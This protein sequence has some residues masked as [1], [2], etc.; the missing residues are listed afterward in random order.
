MK[1]RHVSRG[2]STFGR[3]LVRMVAGIVVVGGLVFGG[4]SLGPSLLG[5]EDDPVVTE[6]PTSEPSSTTTSSSSTSTTAAPVTTVATTTT[7]PVRPPA[8][9]RVLVL[10]SVGTPGLAADVSADLAALGYRTLPPDN[11]GPVVE[12][13]RVWY[14]EGFGGEALE[15][16]AQ[17]PDALVERNEFDAD[18]DIIVVLGAS[19]Q[20]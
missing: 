4:L 14:R 18:A 2:S 16:A 5:S 9:V 7:I 6:T 3:D 11:Y 13:S 12:Q 1:G 17:F 15:L 19:Y 8:E 20:G 10:N